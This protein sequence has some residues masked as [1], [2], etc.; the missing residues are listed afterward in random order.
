MK[1]YLDKNKSQLSVSSGGRYLNY[2]SSSKS[3]RVEPNAKNSWKV[4]DGKL[5]SND[6]CLS[7]TAKKVV[8]CSLAP[9]IYLQFYDSVLYE[10]VHN[11]TDTLTELSTDVTNTMESIDKRVNETSKDLGELEED[12]DDWDNQLADYNSTFLTESNDLFDKIASTKTHMELE[13]NELKAW[14]CSVRKLKQINNNNNNNIRA[15]IPLVH[16]GYSLQS[17]NVPCCYL[18]GITNSVYKPSKTAHSD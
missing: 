14:T 10:Q 16:H 7:D 4:K 15:C 11:L 12:L 8:D 17:R 3:T 18:S 5:N 9:V 1:C 2:E 6:L 13:E